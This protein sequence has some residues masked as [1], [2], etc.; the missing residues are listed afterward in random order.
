MDDYISKPV[1]M[2]ELKAVLESYG[3]SW[4]HSYRQTRAGGPVPRTFSLTWVIYR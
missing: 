2:K 3:K 1:K 4:V